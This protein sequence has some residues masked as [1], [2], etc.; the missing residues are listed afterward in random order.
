MRRA[1]GLAAVA[2]A[3]LA[4]AGWGQKTYYP[5]GATDARDWAQ[6]R[7]RA[8][9]P[10]LEDDA[11]RLIPL[12]TN[13]YDGSQA[14][15]N[16]SSEDVD[17]YSGAS[18]LRVTPLQRHSARIP[19]WNIPIV[20]KPKEGQYRY[21]RFAWKKA[22]GEGV[23]VQ[24]ADM[25]RSWVARYFAGKNV[26]NWQPAKEVSKDVPTEWTVVTRDLYEDFAKANGGTLAISG[27]AFSA[28]DG[29][30]ALFD[31]VVFGRTIA[32]LDAATE[33]AL[34]KGKAGDSLEPKYREALWE[35]LQERDRDR[36]SVALRQ[37]LSTAPDNVGFV[38]ERLT[39]TS[40][41]PEE[42]RDRAK[43]ISTLV[44]RLG[45]EFDFDMRV[46]AEE[47]LEKLG[48]AA[49]PAIRT[50]KQSGDP[51]V[52]YRANRL[53]KKLKIEDGEASLT[54]VRAGRIVRVL[55]RA[56]TTDAKDLL[57]KMADGEYGPEYLEPATAA[58]KRLK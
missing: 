5:G 18:A 34:A 45:G 54:T 4:S 38:A 44:E 37:L 10:V 55:E 28:L 58:V 27:M 29:Q 16:A 11:H 41:S 17:V 35:D 36:A 32:D 14:T 30:Y 15:A 2:T 22:G 46:A 53:H 51:E 7:S 6:V 13:D 43:R 47:E 25:N 52:R 57:K 21:V 49:E 1:F 50:A 24:I 19:N 39:R 26:Q 40:Q 9:M 12:L 3:V 56:G 31:H 42:I 20:E 48:A 33:V 23:M 8:V